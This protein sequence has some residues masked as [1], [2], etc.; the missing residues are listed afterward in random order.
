MTVCVFGCQM[1]RPVLD[2]LAGIP[3]V[4]WLSRSLNRKNM[5]KT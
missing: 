4:D 3:L 2:W 1:G 5:K